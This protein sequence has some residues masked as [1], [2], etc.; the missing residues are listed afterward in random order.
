MDA[1]ASASASGTEDDM[2]PTTEVML[3]VANRLF[4]AVGA[5]TPLRACVAIM[6][7]EMKSRM[8]DCAITEEARKHV[9]EDMD[10]S[11]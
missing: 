1:V 10:S 9:L 6:R 8:H 7:N 11:N 3:L 4:Q 5:G 2:V